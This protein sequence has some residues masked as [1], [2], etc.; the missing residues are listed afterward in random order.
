[1]EGAENIIIQCYQQMS[2]PNPEI[3]Q[4]AVNQLNTLFENP[5]II[6]VL[7]NIAANVPNQRYKDYSIV[8]FSA[9][10][11]RHQINLPTEFILGLKPQLVHLLQ[12]DI[13][14]NSKKIICD[15]LYTWDFQYSKSGFGT[16]FI[17][18]ASQM[19]QSPQLEAAGFYFISKILDY[20]SLPNFTPNLVQHLYQLCSKYL[21]SPDFELRKISYGFLQQ[22]FSVTDLFNQMIGSFEPIAQQLLQHF[23]LLFTTN[24]DPSEATE[25]FNVFSAMMSYL[26]EYFYN[27]FM[28]II[29]ELKTMLLNPNVDSMIRISST[30]LLVVA[31]E[32]FPDVIN[33][34]IDDFIMTLAQF[35]IELVSTEGDQDLLT[36]PSEFYL[37]VAESLLEETDPFDILNIFMQTVQKLGT[38]NNPVSIMIIFMIFDSLSAICIEPM[39]EQFEQFEIFINNALQSNNPTLVESAASFMKTICKESPTISYRLLDTFEPILLNFVVSDIVVDT[40]TSIYDLSDKVPQN[41]QNSLQVLLNQLTTNSANPI[42]VEKIVEAISY[43]VLNVERIE[44]EIFTTVRP[45]LLQLLQSGVDGLNSAIFCFSAFAHSSPVLV[46]NDLASLADAINSALQMNDLRLNNNCAN[47]ITNLIDMLP[48]SFGQYCPQLLPS[49]ISIFDNDNLS[50]QLNDDD[51]DNDDNPENLEFMEKLQYYTA[52]RC[53]ILTAITTIFNTFPKE[54]E[55]QADLI[56]ERVIKSLHAL[57]ESVEILTG[58]YNASRELV[59]GFLKINKDPSQIIEQLLE[60]SNMFDD[61]DTIVSFWDTIAVIITSCG[62]PLLDKYGESIFQTLLNIFN[63]K[64]AYSK[65]KKRFEL[66]KELIRPITKVVSRFFVDFGAGGAQYAQAGIDFLKNIVKTTKNAAGLAARTISNIIKVYAP[67]LNNLINETLGLVSALVTSKN[68][69]NREAA[70]DTINTLLYLNSSSI[71]NQVPQ[72]IQSTFDVIVNNTKYS[73]LLIESAVALWCSCVMVYKVQITQEQLECVL[74]YFPPSSN[75]VLLEYSA[76]FAVYAANQWPSVFTAEELMC[77]A[78]AVFAS[79]DY[80]MR[81]I[82]PENG[83]FLAS[84]L[85]STPQEKIIENIR[86]DENQ[87]LKIQRHVAQFS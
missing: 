69:E 86:S 39:V 21:A 20:Q 8:N 73:N 40:L 35:T 56:A 19:L 15:Q 16:D 37:K 22:L 33:S 48:Q 60:S 13:N 34:Q 51:N 65:T 74:N 45:F 1:M 14:L 54:L 81:V 83:S 26:D 58:A 66:R 38:T 67:Q 85:S 63:H 25:I 82:P 53:D 29:T 30:C 5:Q 6:S 78:I 4:A 77:T 17:V 70:F 52:M 76:S 71:Q 43:L 84:V 7:L 23:H 32:I 75:S 49:L 68:D 9:S 47:A 27:T 57:D 2:D 10:I 59:P 41:Y 80:V 72:I 18:I 79:D 42:H 44:D 87:L 31:C 28:P 11:R 46:K 12:T 64:E 36:T 24:Q 62:R 50:P 55:S 3:A 61:V